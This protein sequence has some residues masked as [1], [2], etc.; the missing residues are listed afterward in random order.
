MGNYLG[1]LIDRSGV[2]R[3]VHK[4]ECVHDID[5]VESLRH[6]LAAIDGFESGEVWRDRDRIALIISP[7]ERHESSSS[8]H[9]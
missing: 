2:I 6:L 1:F 4:I 8:G 3:D 5:A 7:R 9:R